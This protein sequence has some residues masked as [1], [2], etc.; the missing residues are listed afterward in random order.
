[1]KKVLVLA[2]VLFSTAAG[3]GSFQQDPQ[4]Q[5]LVLQQAHSIL[6]TKQGMDKQWFK[7]LA[8]LADRNSVDVFYVFNFTHK[9]SLST[10]AAMAAKHANACGFGAYANERG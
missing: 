6:C 2:C 1:M 10:A 5:T 4:F 9:V 8:E 3:A 7:Q